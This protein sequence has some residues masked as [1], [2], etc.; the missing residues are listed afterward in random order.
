MA[1]IPLYDKNPTKKSPVI[2][3]ILIILCIMI[4]VLQSS[5]SFHENKIFILKFGMIPSVLLGVS[6]LSPEIRVIPSI[7][8]S[9]TYIFLHGSWLHLIGNMIYLY[10]FGDNIEDCLGKKKYLLFFVLCGCF[11][12]FSQA[13]INMNSNIPMIG[14]SGS[15]FGILGAYFILFPKAKIKV[16]LFIIP[17]NIS[18]MYL[19]GGYVFLQFLLLDTKSSDESIAYIA[20]IGGFFSGI[21][22]IKILIK[23]KIF[24]NQ[25]TNKGTLPSSK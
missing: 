17:F 16:L 2:N 6:E 5:L 19:I 9:I 12:G 15:V 8:S 20:H 24:N 11:A 7:L 23:R 25:K 4:F 21:I 18:S 14:A 3:W 1:L 22:L 10:I 13:F